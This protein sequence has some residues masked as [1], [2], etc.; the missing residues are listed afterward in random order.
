M[1]SIAQNDTNQLQPE[2]HKGTVKNAPKIKSTSQG[3]EL[4]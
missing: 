3:G 4:L 2:A 1:K